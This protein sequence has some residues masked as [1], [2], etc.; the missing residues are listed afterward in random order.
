MTGDISKLKDQLESSSFVLKKRD[1]V[2]IPIALWLCWLNGGLCNSIT[3]VDWEESMVVIQETFL[4]VRRKR[5]LMCSF[6]KWLRLKLKQIGVEN[7]TSSKIIGVEVIWRPARD[8]NPESGRWTWVKGGRRRY[9][10]NTQLRGTFGDGL[11]AAR[12][13]IRRVSKSTWWDWPAGSRSFFWR[14]PKACWESSRDGRKNYIRDKLSI[15]SLPDTPVQVDF[16]ERE[17][18]RVKSKLLSVLDKG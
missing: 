12:D 17:R 6:V 1:D 13:C 3:V 2:S 15:N 4:L 16:R 9:K 5:V 10:S 8:L 14:W 11:E 18:E 7:I